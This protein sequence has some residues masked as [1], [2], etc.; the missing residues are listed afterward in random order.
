[1]VGDAEGRVGLLN[2]D[3]VVVGA[4]KDLNGHPFSDRPHGA[5]I[6]PLVEKKPQAWGASQRGGGRGDVL[7][8]GAVGVE[9]RRK[10]DGMKEVGQKV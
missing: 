10:A 3:G 9:P 2:S 6:V 8:K 4:I 7:G 5:L 1:M